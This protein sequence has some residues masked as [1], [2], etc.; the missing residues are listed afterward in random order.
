MVLNFS[1]FTNYV[2]LIADDAGTSDLTC[3]WWDNTNGP[4]NIV[5]VVPS[6]YTP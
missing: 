6:V 2:E 3:N 5:S 4:Q 1:D